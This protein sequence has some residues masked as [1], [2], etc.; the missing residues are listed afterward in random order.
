MATGQS[1]RQFFQGLDDQRRE[2]LAREAGTTVEY[3]EH[4][5]LRG[6]RQPRRKLVDRLAAA[7]ATLGASFSSAQVM[8]SCLEAVSA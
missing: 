7:C 4:H 2:Q 3:I 8:A 5:L 6:R 1:F